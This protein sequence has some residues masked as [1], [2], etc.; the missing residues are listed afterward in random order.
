MGA[1][2][3][4]AWVLLAVAGLRAGLSVCALLSDMDLRCPSCGAAIPG[5][6]MATDTAMA[7]PSKTAFAQE[8]LLVLIN[9]RLLNKSSLYVRIIGLMSR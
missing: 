5:E 4:G 3:S 1:T 6:A 9:W 7:V 8:C 2:A